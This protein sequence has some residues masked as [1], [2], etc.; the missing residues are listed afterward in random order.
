MS[1]PEYGRTFRIVAGVDGSPPSLEA[2]R[3]AVRQAELTG[4]T[5]DA[6]IAWQFPYAV[7]G[8]SWAPT[9]GLDNTDYAGVAAKSLGAAVAAV[10]PPPSVKVRELV[11]EG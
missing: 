10:S 8:L 4:G 7:G 2:L 3:W 6:V 11:V 9:A 1:A 5:V